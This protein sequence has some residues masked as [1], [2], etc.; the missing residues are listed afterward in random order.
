[1]EANTPDFPPAARPPA[2][3]GSLS[4]AARGNELK[5]VQRIL[6][7]IGV[8]TMAV[9]GFGLYN[10]ENEIEQAIRQNQIAPQFLQET[11]IYGY[12]IYGLP[13]LLGLLFVVFGVIIKRF[14]VPITITSLVLYVLAMAAFGYLDPATLAQGFIV[15]IIIIYALFQAIKA[16][17]AFQAH[18]QKPK[19]AEELLG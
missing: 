4:Q 12:L 19:V 8:L 2:P 1:V 7:V 15:K 5:R 14:P 6:F 10:L 16:A 13:A 11:R 9:N 3:L 17:R 18:E